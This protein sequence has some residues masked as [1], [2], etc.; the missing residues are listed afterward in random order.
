MCGIAGVIKFG[1]KPITEEQCTLLLIGNE[2]RGNDATGLAFS[3]PDGSIQIYKKDVPA[4][5]FTGSKQYREFIKENLHDD[6][7][8]VIVHTRGATQGSPRQNKNNHPISGGQACIIHNGCLSNDDQ[9]FRQLGADRAAETDSDI[10][11]AYVDE[12]GITTKCIK[13]MNKI[14][15]SAAGAAFDPRSPKKMLLFRS[16][17]PMIL[18]SNNDYFMFSSEKGTLYKAMKP[19]VKRH[20]MWFQVEQP[21]TAFAPMA[22]HTAWIV[23][24][25]GQEQHAEFKTLAYSYNEPWRKTY[26][27]YSERQARW[28]RKEK[29]TELKALPAPKGNENRPIMVDAWCN[30]CRR[31]WGVPKGRDPKEFNCN[32]KSGGCGKSLVAIDE[33]DTKKGK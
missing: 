12:Y 32:K 1:E 7:W 28:D 11:R 21:D 19:F 2:H 31:V 16:G 10:L 9:L 14:A 4:W 25:E 18:S 27:N 26:E 8:G 22:D 17:S 23:G 3:Q 20:N 24:E 29:V 15:G 13:E 33:I 6:T 30:A 5:Q